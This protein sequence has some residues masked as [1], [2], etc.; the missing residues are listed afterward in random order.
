MKKT[1][2]TEDKIIG[3]VKQPEAG[4]S[5]YGKAAPRSI[6]RIAGP[7]KIVKLAGER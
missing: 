6:R 2:H 5:S 1:K 3:A 7:E 4:R